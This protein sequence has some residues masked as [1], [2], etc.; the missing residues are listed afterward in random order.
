[1]HEGYIPAS[2][3]LWRVIE[4]PEGYYYEIKLQGIIIDRIKIDYPALATLKNKGV[5]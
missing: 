1:M 5:I 4:Q 3:K 2:Q